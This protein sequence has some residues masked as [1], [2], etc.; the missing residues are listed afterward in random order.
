M[1]FKTYIYT[2]SNEQLQQALKIAEEIKARDETFNYYQAG[3][4][5][6]IL[7]PDKDKAYRRGLLFTRR[8]LKDPKLKFTVVER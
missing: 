2:S 7:S 6:V 8:Y 5:L 1:K 3:H 4:T